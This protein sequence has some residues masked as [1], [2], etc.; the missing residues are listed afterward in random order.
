MKNPMVT[1]SVLVTI[2]ADS[3]YEG[4]AEFAATLPYDQLGYLEYLSPS[5]WLLADLKEKAI[6]EFDHMNSEERNP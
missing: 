1:I 5:G 6:K 4:S 3:M 2:A